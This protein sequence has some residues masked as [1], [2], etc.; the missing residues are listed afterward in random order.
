MLRISVHPGDTLA[1]AGGIDAGFALLR[2]AGVEG[3]Q[4][5]LRQYLMPAETMKNGSHTVLDEPLE[6][7]LE[8]VRPYKEAA[9]KYGIAI[10][11][12]HAPFPIWRA[13]DDAYNARMGEILR[14]SVAL[15]AY[16]ECPHVIIHPAGAAVNSE[17][18]SAEAEWELNRQ[19]LGALIP[20]LR[21][22]GVTA[23]LENLFARGIDGVL[24]AGV[25][26]DFREACRWIDALNAQ[27]GAECFGFCLD[28]GHCHLAHQNL[29]RAVR[30]LG[31][32]L[33]ALHLQDN[34]GHLDDHRAPYMGNIDWPSFLDSLRAIGYRGDL[35]FE[36]IY[37]INRYPAE[38][39]EDCL[40]LLAQTGQY[41]R[42]QI[43][44]E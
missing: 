12:V 43:L 1:R 14:K 27:A 29:N 32:R 15:T 8:A 3:I 38:L 5:G 39:T 36:A 10:S 6:A 20:T 11:Q 33:K 40:R 13:E 21:E 44:A 41:F 18:L 24:Y 34:F 23:L 19:L 17:R 28:T 35:N 9:Q 42:Q 7:V 30:V 16:M 4:F 22:Y 25:C 31:P 2:R 37:A 26:A